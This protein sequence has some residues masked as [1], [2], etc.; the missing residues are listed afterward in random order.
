MRYLANFILVA[1]VAAVDVGGARA[2]DL[3][4]SAPPSDPPVDIRFVPDSPCVVRFPAE[5]WSAEHTPERSPASAGLP[6]PPPGWSAEE[7]A[8]LRTAMNIDRTVS[9]PTEEIDQHPGRLSVNKSGFFQKLS[10]QTGWLSRADDADLG[11]TEAKLLVTVALPVPTRDFPMLVTPGFDMTWLDGPSSPDL[12]PVLYSGYVDF[13]WLPKLSDRWMGILALAPGVYSDFQDVQDDARR[14][15]AK[16][17][18]RFDW[19]PNRLQLM[20]G[21]LYLNR[22]DVNWLP[23]GGLIWAPD[24]DTQ[25]EFIFPR[26]KLARRIRYDGVSEDWV[27][28]GGEFGGDTWSIQR[29][30][31]QF[32]M[33]TLVD[34]RAFL[35]LE[36]RRA[37]GV[38]QRVEV[39]YVFDREVTFITDTPDYTCANTIM[40]R[41]SIDF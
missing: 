10:L 7:F 25:L 17:L 14:L 18:A 24:D 19:V 26:P 16:M 28:L 1:T 34:W 40:L 4:G 29:D 13:M 21:V 15:K 5:T 27:Y 22:N 39:G 8:S 41:G 31:G 6:P 23:A 20:F 33:I 2:A 35:G 3:W 12:P 38:S 11:L 32:D 9:V 36:R 37:G 30:S